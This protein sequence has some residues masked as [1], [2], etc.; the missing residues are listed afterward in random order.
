MP[1]IDDMD[2]EKQA[3]AAKARDD[4]FDDALL[5]VL[6]D[7]RGRRVMWWLLSVCGVFRVSFTGN[8]Q[9]F[10]NEGMRNVGLQVMGRIMKVKPS[11]YEEMHRESQ[12]DV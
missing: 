7:A 12:Q 2:E 1:D 11:V 3:E 5:W 9:T 4:A 10:F 8:S 6:S